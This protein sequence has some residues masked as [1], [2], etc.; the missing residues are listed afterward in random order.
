M[1]RSMVDIKQLLKYNDEVRHRYFECLTKL[2][3]TGF[4]EDKGASWGSMRN[5]LIHTLGATDYWLDFLKG[6]N[7]HADKEFEDYATFDDVKRYMKHVEKR[8]QNYLGSLSAKGLQKE[9]SVENDAGEK[10]KITVEDVLVHVFE[11]EVHH[12]GELIALLWQMDVRPPLMGWKE[13]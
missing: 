11:E 4:V 12:R 2:G 3:W 10:V 13:L 7:V 6:E 1:V 9:Y 5:I 8:M